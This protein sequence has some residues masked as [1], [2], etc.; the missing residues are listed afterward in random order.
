MAKINSVTFIKRNAAWFVFG[1]FVFLAIYFHQG[2]PL[3][4]SQGDLPLGK[5]IIWII[6]LSFLLFSI[7]CSAKENIVKTVKKMYPM[8]W[9]KQ[10]G[11]DLYIGFLITLLIIYLNEGSLLILALWILPVLV[12]GNLATLLYLALNYDSIVSQFI[13]T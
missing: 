6:F 5:P 4:F 10:I 12:F 13:T 11:I 1:V 3:F 7:H 8:Y 9:G 2:E